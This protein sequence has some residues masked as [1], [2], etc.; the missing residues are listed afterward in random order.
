[1]KLKNSSNN[2]K[3]LLLDISKRRI[4]VGLFLCVL[5]SIIFYAFLIT[6]GKTYIL[7]NAFSNDYEL[8]SL[9]EKVA[10]YYSFLLAFIAVYFSFSLIFNFML[11]RPK[12]FLS[13][14]NY[15][16]NTILNQQRVTNWFLINWFFR[17]ATLFGILAIDHK[18][19]SFFI[20]NFYLIILLII[21]FVGQMWISIRCFFDKNKLQWFFVSIFTFLT[22]AFLISKIE[23]IDN[24]AIDK[25]ILA[26]NTIYRLNIKRVNSD[27]HQG[28]PEHRSLYFN[29]YL[30]EKE[31]SLIIE[32]D[33]NNSLLKGNSLKGKIKNFKKRISEFE[34]PYINY[35]LHVDANVNVKHLFEVKKSLKEEG[36]NNMYYS[37]LDEKLPFYYKSTKA[38]GFK[39]LQNN[40][41]E[42]DPSFNRIEI[43]NN[44]KILFQNDTLSKADLEKFIRNRINKVGVS[45]FVLSV[46]NNTNFKEYFN[47]LSITKSVINEFR[48]EYSKKAYAEDF[49][50]LPKNLRNP[51]KEKF[52]WVVI[53]EN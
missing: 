16:R 35:I 14:Y 22:L 51:I 4:Y 13:K 49:L 32:T 36:A 40:I 46:K 27:I 24:N 39:L 30:K 6:T 2:K 18:T 29:I 19:S 20:D 42:N 11:E 45:P 8:I 34:Y 43:L 37:L 12:Q 53:D 9:P 41:K 1:M 52:Y 15:K 33:F 21:A 7:F 47:V 23:V 25:S 38:F 5:F 10:E 28:L 31:S 26:R 48:N 17:I 3:H 44:E 50:S